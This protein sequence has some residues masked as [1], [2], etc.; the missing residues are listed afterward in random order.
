MQSPQGALAADTARWRAGKQLTSQASSL[1]GIGSM[2]GCSRGDGNDNKHNRTPSDKKGALCTDEGKS[3]VFIF[4]LG[5]E[6]KKCSGD[7][8]DAMQEQSQILRSRFLTYCTCKR[9]I[10]PQHNWKKAPT[11]SLARLRAL[12]Y[13]GSGARPHGLISDFLGFLKC[14]KK[15]PCSMHISTKN[16]ISL[17]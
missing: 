7:C 17:F 16:W 15:S 8:G 6:V 12:Q 10:L 1:G 13:D 9:S 11:S 2:E 5:T 4:T 14:Q 3:L